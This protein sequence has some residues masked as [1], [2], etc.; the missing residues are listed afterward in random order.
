[1]ATIYLFFGKIMK[2]HGII[3]ME[4]DV[5]DALGCMNNADFEK[6]KQMTILC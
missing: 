4:V 5:L 2:K 1:M 3:Q 6:R